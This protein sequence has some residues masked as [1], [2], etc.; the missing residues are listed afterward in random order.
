[1]D[2]WRY[3]DLL[4]TF[5]W[6][7]ITARYRQSVLGIGWAI[8][9]PALTVA[10]FTIVFSR[11]VSLSS[12]AVPYPL[13]CLTGLLPW[14]FFS[15][16]LT[17]A[18]T[19]VVSAG[20]LLT[21]VY[22]PR[23]ILPIAGVIVALCELLIQLLFL[24]LVM[25]WYQHQPG[26]VLLS[27]IGFLT[28]AMITSFAFGLWLT[29]LNVKYRDVGMAVPFLLQAWMWLCP[30]AYSMNLIPAKW[31]FLYSL[32]PMAG[33]IEGFRWACLGPTAAP[34]DWLALGISTAAATLILVTGAYYF[35][36]REASFADVV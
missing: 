18:S 9:K 29:A 33:V 32:N 21:K 15:N 24:A 34:P 28:L 20:S 4:W 35:R 3:R 23:M 25:A 8:F 16:A 26:L 5:V 30:V 31:R 6:R 36:L 27:A 14:L 7:D 22:F 13:F 17:N 12:D 1:M 2:L 19:S 10:I 11:V